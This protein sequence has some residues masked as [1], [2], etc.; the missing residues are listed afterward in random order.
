MVKPLEYGLEPRFPFLDRR[1]ADFV[2]AA[3]LYLGARP[4]PGNSKWLLRQALIGVL[5]EKI[6]QR[7]Y[8]KISWSEYVEQMMCNQSRDMLQS[9]FSDT[10]MA[11]YQF[12]DDRKLLSDFEAYCDGISKR[13]YSKF[14]YFT[15]CLERWLR[16][17]TSGK[18]TVCFN[19]L[20]PWQFEG[21]YDECMR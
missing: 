19:Q 4:G 5:P 13:R 21:S 10:Q 6:R 11:H 1:L 3:P 14:F 16:T 17:Y 2:L 20:Q 12:L 18:A 7:P 8:T 15:M 9:L